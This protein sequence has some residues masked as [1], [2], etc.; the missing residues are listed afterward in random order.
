MCLL[1]IILTT[2][3][4]T[5]LNHEFVF[6]RAHTHT[7]TI[8]D[9]ETRRQYYLASTGDG[10]WHR[11][12]L[13]TGLPFGVSFSA[14]VSPA[15][16]LLSQFSWALCSLS[17]TYLQSAYCTYTQSRQ[18]LRTWVNSNCLCLALNSLRPALSNSS[19]T[20][21]TDTLL[22]QIIAL[23]APSPVRTVNQ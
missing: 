1:G 11:L 3:E 13:S 8:S 17:L 4:T 7:H 2:T 9:S 18:Y 22:R 20:T 6:V 12:A 10:Q 16:L 23:T 14:T 19:T 15:L 5:I 21:T